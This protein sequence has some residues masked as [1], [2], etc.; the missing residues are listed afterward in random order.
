MSFDGI[1]TRAVTYELK[2]NLIGSKVDK[3][4]QQE[5]D[6]ILIHLRK[7]GKNYKLLISASSNNPRLYLTESSKQNPSS[8]PM[9]CMLMRKHLVG[10]VITNISQYE[11]D[12]VVSIDIKSMDEMGE[13]SIK[14]LIIEIM[15]KYSNIILVD[16]AK[17]VIID[18]I[19]RVAADMSRIR[20]V[21]P[22]L[23]YEFPSSG[24]KINPLD[25]NLTTFLEKINN[26]NKN[27]PVFKFFYSNFIG[28]SPLI[29]REICYRSSV[30]ERKTLEYLDNNEKEKLFNTF[31]NIM[32]EVSL[33]KYTPNIV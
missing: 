17:N 1:V 10:G 33:N 5:K 25:I 20:Q 12:R 19:K 30:D 7:L 21:L 32:N 15:G 26:N 11:L 18:S 14:H 24:N 6:E 31:S 4:Y 23:E 8:P 2:Q 3:I 28:L 13:L 27:I 22:G 16:E 9:F 29:S